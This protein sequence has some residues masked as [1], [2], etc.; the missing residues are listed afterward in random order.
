MIQVDMADEDLR[1]RKLIEHWAEHNDEHG[2]RFEEEAEKASERGLKEVA[3]NLRAAAKKA[4]EV[5]RALRKALEA[6]S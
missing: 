1:L 5:S 3:D 6:F 2:G 4:A